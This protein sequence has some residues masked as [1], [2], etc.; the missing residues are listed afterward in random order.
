M[1]WFRSNPFDIGTTTSNGLS[2]AP[3]LEKMKVAARDCNDSYKDLGGVKANGALMR[4]MPLVLYGMYL[5]NDSLYELM[6]S[7]AE[8][9]HQNELIYVVNTCYAIMCIYLLKNHAN[10]GRNAEAYNEMKKWLESVKNERGAKGAVATEILHW[11]EDV[12][13]KKA[14]E[15]AI[16]EFQGYVKI[17]FQRHAII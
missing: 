12:E 8:L 1:G 10:R 11:L 7:D 13:G 6:K 9:T 16:S 5:D 4:C 15:S 14:M 3:D 17:A 2:K